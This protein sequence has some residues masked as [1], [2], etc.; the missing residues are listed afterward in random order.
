MPDSRKQGATLI[1]P[2]CLRMWV[3][4]TFVGELIGQFCVVLTPWFLQGLK[5]TESP[6]LS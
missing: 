6:A 2:V 1:R 3:E 4:F 5:R